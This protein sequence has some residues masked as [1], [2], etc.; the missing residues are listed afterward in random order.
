VYKILVRNSEVKNPF[1]RPRRRG[2]DSIRMDLRE[3]WW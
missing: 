1:G 3:I 2:E